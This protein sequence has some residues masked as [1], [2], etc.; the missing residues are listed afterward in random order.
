MEGTLRWKD[1]PLFI[2]F[3]DFRAAFDTASR[4]T[5]VWKLACAGVP[6]SILDLLSSIL[7]EN[8][9]SIDDGVAQH[10]PF[11]QT[12]GVPQGDCLSP[13]LFSTLLGDLPNIIQERHRA[14]E[15][16][17]YA[18]DLALISQSEF[19]LQ[20]SMSTLVEHARKCG[21]EINVGKTMSMRVSR[22]GRQTR[23]PKFRISGEYIPQVNYFSYLGVIIPSDGKSYGRHIRER[24]C[25]AL[26]VLEP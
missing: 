7:K 4:E 13:L 6:R 11:F 9:I 2:V 1:I 5:I 3:V 12:T 17:M 21:L 16:V 18:D 22:T 24:V 8:M 26:K 20:Q 14:V 19:H 25:Q 23:A 10:G 15:A